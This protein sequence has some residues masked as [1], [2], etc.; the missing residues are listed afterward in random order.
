MREKRT[1]LAVGTGVS[2]GL[3]TLARAEGALFA[4]ILPLSLMWVWRRDLRLLSFPLIVLLSAAA[5]IAPWLVRNHLGTTR[6]RLA[7]EPLMFMLVTSYV[8]QCLSHGQ[9]SDS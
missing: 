7:V 3:T 9:P 6:W 8:W 4:L 2:C 5:V 1:L